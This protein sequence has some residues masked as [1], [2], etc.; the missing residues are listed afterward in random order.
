MTDFGGF[1]CPVFARWC[2]VLARFGHRRRMTIETQSC[3]AD[4]CSNIR[5]G[6]VGFKS[7]HRCLKLVLLTTDP[8]AEPF[9]AISFPS[10]PR[11]Q[12]SAAMRRELFAIRSPV[13][14]EDLHFQQRQ[15]QK[16]NQQKEQHKQQQQQQQQQTQQQQ[17][18]EHETKRARQPS[19]MLLPLKQQ[20]DEETEANEKKRARWQPSPGMI[21]AREALGEASRPGPSPG[22]ETLSPCKSLY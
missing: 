17:P 18:Q 12:R 10:R 16:R 8:F 14:A 19:P 2:K 3:F 22:H 7:Q 15:Q 11:Q 1:E 13:H 6:C 20:D 21:R 9:A 4:I 5:V